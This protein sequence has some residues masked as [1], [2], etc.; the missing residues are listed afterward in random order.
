MQFFAGK[1][2]SVLTLTK[3]AKRFA[4][5]KMAFI[6]TAKRFFCASVP[7]HFRGNSGDEVT[8]LEL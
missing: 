8:L 6:D 3:G 4:I 1:K 2:G 7:P 5:K